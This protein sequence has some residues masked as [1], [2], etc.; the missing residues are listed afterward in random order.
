MMVFP[1]QKIHVTTQSFC[2]LRGKIVYI[3]IIFQSHVVMDA[4]KILETTGLE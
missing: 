3:R 1:C 4:D 2:M